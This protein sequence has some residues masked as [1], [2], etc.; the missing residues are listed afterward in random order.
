MRVFLIVLAVS[1]GMS[2]LLWNF[3]LAAKIWPSHPLLATTLLAM[4][5]AIAVQTIL[6][7]AR[8]TQKEK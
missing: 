4:G 5:C 6:N 8:S 1:I 7:R 2:I 3:G